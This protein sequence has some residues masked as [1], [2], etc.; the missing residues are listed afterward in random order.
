MKPRGSGGLG[1]PD[2]Y[3]Y[4]LAYNTRSP[5]S[6]AY[7]CKSEAG[8]WKW[9]EEKILSEY[10]KTVSLPALWYHP[11]IDVKMDNTLI[12][13]SCEIVKSLQKCLAF[14]GPSLPSCPRWNNSLL[15]AGG[16]TLTN[17]TWQCRGINQLGQIVKDGDMVPFN[18]LKNMFVLRDVEF[19]SYLQ[20][21][22][23]IKSLISK[24]RAT[25]LNTD[26]DIKLKGIAS[27][28]E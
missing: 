4:Y 24:N 6:W 5:L 10:S 26:L 20:L 3:S 13:F 22:S 14:D 18:E 9:V 17:N 7:T 16:R 1:I 23:I 25:G 15:I 11:K 28:E 21:R 12:Q 2:V 27:V 8:S 19:L